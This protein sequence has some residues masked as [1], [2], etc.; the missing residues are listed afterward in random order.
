MNILD[1]RMFN[2]LGESLY[3]YNSN[4]PS[5]ILI[6]VICMGIT[7]GECW[8]YYT[9]MMDKGLRPG[10]RQWMGESL[11]GYHILTQAKQPAKHSLWV[12]QLL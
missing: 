4:T 7:L 12:L 5:R 6:W 8:G 10:C 2:G 1:W 9:R 3:G 11:Y